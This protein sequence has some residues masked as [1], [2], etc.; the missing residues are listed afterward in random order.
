MHRKR[1]FFGLTH[2]TVSWKI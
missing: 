1:K 2:C